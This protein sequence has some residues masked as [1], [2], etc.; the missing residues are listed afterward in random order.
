MPVDNILAPGALLIFSGRRWQVQ[1]IHAESRV[2][3]VEPAKAGVP[4]R[5]GGNAGLIHDRVVERMFRILG[6]HAVPA[7]LDPLAVA[8]L[9][10]ARGSFAA[11]GGGRILALSPQA[12]LLVTR[13]GTVASTTLALALQSVGFRV[14][15][16]DGF[17]EVLGTDATP[18]LR[19]FLAGIAQG[20][21]VDLFAHDPPL[22]FEKFHPFLTQPLLQRDALSSRV[23]LAALASLC[24]ELTD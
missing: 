17:L 13:R 12:F 1:E 10:Q 11:L 15:P 23:D 21:S 20:D 22:S 19:A 18:D 2:I 6:E 24:K 8:L 7:Y 16:Y 5:F 3:V 4:P 14:Q 9:E